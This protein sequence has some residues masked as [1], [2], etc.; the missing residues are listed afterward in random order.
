V[1]EHPVSGAVRFSFIAGNPE[2]GRFPGSDSKPELPAI[3][4]NVRRIWTRIQV[5]LTMAYFERRC[6]EHCPGRSPGRSQSIAKA[7]DTI[8]TGLLSVALNRVTRPK[9]MVRPSRT[10]RASASTSDC[11]T[12]RMKWVV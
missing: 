1:L 5:S 4:S 6:L 9:L 7:L 2:E 3:E 8:A 10:T 12:A 11:A